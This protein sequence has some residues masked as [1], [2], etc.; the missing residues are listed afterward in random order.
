MPSTGGATLDVQRDPVGGGAVR[1]CPATVHRLGQVPLHDL[2][3][4][5]SVGQ[6]RVTLFVERLPGL[7]PVFSMAGQN[8][9]QAPCFNGV[10]CLGRLS[11]CLALGVA[12][13]FGVAST[14]V[15]LTAPIHDQVML[16]AGSTRGFQVAYQDPQA[17]G[18]GLNLSPGLRVQI[19]PW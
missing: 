14:A 2:V 19:C 3:G 13:V 17:G 7:Q 9:T 10:P 1:F 6:N 15:D 8:F 18:V 12:D 11:L 5:S 16:L 4:S